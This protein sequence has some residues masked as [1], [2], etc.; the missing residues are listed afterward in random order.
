MPEGPEAPATQIKQFLHDSNF[1]VTNKDMEYLWRSLALGDSFN[2][3]EKSY[4]EL[5]AHI[6]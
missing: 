2:P 5:I 4:N 3:K 1:L 6:A